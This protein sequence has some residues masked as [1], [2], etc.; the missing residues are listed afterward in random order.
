MLE[1]ADLTQKLARGEVLVKVFAAALNLCASYFPPMFREI[2]V[3]PRCYHMMKW[4][5]G[6]LFNRIAEVD[7][8]GEIIDPNRSEFSAGDK[9]F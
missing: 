4:L 2:D 3:H 7:L 5:A 1:R 9:V 8:A 6:P